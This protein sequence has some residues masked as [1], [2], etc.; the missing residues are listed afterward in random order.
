MKHYKLN[1]SQES[2]YL[3]YKITNNKGSYNIGGYQDIY[4]EIN[5]DF[6]LYIKSIKIAIQNN[7]IFF[8]NMITDE[9][10][11]IKQVINKSDFDM[12][13]E[14]VSSELNPKEFA[15]KRMKE[16]LV[17]PLD[18]EKEKGFK[19][20][21]YK[22]GTDNYYIY[23]K[24]SH[25][26][27]DGHGSANLLHQAVYIYNKLSNNED[28]IKEEL[29]KNFLEINEE[30]PSKIKERSENY[31]KNK[32]LT[33]PPVLEDYKIDF[34]NGNVED[35]ES[36]V[37]DQEIPFDK[38]L[39]MNNKMK[40][41]GAT[42]HQ[43][44]TSALILFIHNEHNLNDICL[45]I[46][47]HG[48]N[49]K[50]LKDVVGTFVRMI[51]NRFI[52]KEEITLK[53]L[54]EYVTKVQREDIK[55]SKLSY[56]EI[57]RVCKS[58]TPLF[59]MS[60]NYHFINFEEK[61]NNHISECFVVSNDLAQIPLTLLFCQHGQTNLLKIRYMNKIVS[62]ERAKRLLDLSIEFLD[63]IVE[64]ENVK[65]N[66]LNFINEQHQKILEKSKGENTDITLNIKKELELNNN[67]LN[68]NL[69]NEIEKLNITED[70][71]IIIK[72]DRSKNLLST[73]YTL[74][75]KGITYIPLKKNILKIKE[76]YIINNSKANFIIEESG[77]NI[78]IYR[79]SNTK[80]SYKNIAYI[81]YTSGSTGKPKG[82]KNT[83]ENL[84]NYLQNANDYYYKNLEG[85]IFCTDH[86]FDLT[87]PTI[88]LPATKNHEVHL[89]SN[90]NEM[91]DLY[92]FIKNNKK[93][94]LIR[95]TPSHLSGLLDFFN[96]DEIYKNK[97][98][99]VIGGEKL[100]LN[101]VK[102]IRNIFPKSKI[103]NHYGPTEGTIG[104]TIFEIPE[105]FNKNIPIGLPFDNVKL[106]VLNEK[107]KNAISNEIGELYISGKSLS[108]GYVNSENDND[109]F[110]KFGEDVFY[111][112]G[113][114]VKW[115]DN[116]LEYIGRKDRQ[117]KISGQRV[118][119]AEI[120][121]LILE[122]NLIKNVFVNFE[123]NTLY[124]YVEFFEKQ[125]ENIINILNENL[126]DNLKIKIATEHTFILNERNKIITN[127]LFCPKIKITEE[128]I[129]P[130][131]E[132]E[133]F[134]YDQSCILLETQ[135]L[136]MDDSFLKKG[137]NSIL[138]TKL[139]AKIKNKF[140]VYIDM[141]SL[142]EVNTLKDFSHLLDK[143]IETSNKLKKLDDNDFEDGMTI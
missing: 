61:I 122:N 86:S 127:N 12:P 31:W 68:K 45:G 85:S 137:G 38:I 115:N 66:E 143:E 50:T 17:I 58:N 131:T 79:L 48:R 142:Y 107:M 136:S 109:S 7:D 3:E 130:Q 81:I 71:A 124:A 125:N 108:D 52:L 112:T 39:K 80:T 98:S 88:L 105:K 14:D 32:F 100:S 135:N 6:N 43:L 75:S 1:N 111:K 102:K 69:L 101:Y 94:L 27:N 22:I 87:V 23:Y 13:I 103:F 140:N 129:L 128:N 114:L 35:F 113:D 133:T 120:E 44:F 93:N 19:F 11:N 67:L 96:K 24:M 16:D 47:T 106:K 123:N 74:I 29:P 41:M 18:I 10:G 110:V 95:L 26:L 89:I 51:P 84:N 33:K 64:N 70:D 34:L 56:P 90:E 97:Y 139:L 118:E 138:I 15:I 82:V 119:M 55:Y 9:E 40:E 83:Y 77:D 5:I 99:F 2:M 46:P 65:I 76:K 132:I 8:C 63:I 73:I 104:S 36:K 117:F 91:F 28:I 78:I 62:K 92:S 25:I 49:K 37:I 30:L 126:F 54:I 42:I 134:I 121:Y 53:E 21:I 57:A 4:P 116:L 59:Q 60:F 20:I 141:K 72:M